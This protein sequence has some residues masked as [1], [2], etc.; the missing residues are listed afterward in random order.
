MLKTCAWSVVRSRGEEALLTNDEALAA[1]DPG[2]GGCCLKCSHCFVAF[3]SCL[4]LLCLHGQC[5]GVV[6][7]SW[8]GF[9]SSPLKDTASLNSSPSVRLRSVA[10]VW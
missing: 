7:G 8:D 5:T 2:W 9:Y 6:H 3:C 4:Q 10:I 1:G